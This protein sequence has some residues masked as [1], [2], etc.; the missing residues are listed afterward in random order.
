[1]AGFLGTRVGR[2][3]AAVIGATLLIAAALVIGREIPGRP[4]IALAAVAVVLALG[5]TAADAALIPLLLLPVVFVIHRVSAGAL[6]LSISDAALGLATLVALVFTK[7]PFSAPLRNLLWLTVLY[8]FATL[9]TVVANPFLAN[10]VEWVH[11]WTLVGGALV[12]GWTIGRGGHARAGLT[13]VMVT[14]LVLAMITIAQGLRQYAG[15]DFQPV[16]VSW[17]YGMHKNFIGTVVAFAAVV[18]YARPV[19]LGWPRR[20]SLSVFWILAVAI[21]FTQSRQAIMGLGVALLLIALRGDRHRR[22]SKVIVVAV[23]PALFFVGTLVKDQLASGNAFNS[24]NQRLT[25]FQDTLT[26]WERS[27][28][29]GYGLRFWNQPGAPLHFQPP[30]A[31][32]EVLASAGIIGLLGFLALV[33]GVLIVLWRIDPAYGTLAVAVVL[34]RFVQGQFDLFWVAGQVSVPFVVAGICLGVLELR[35][36]G[37]EPSQRL[38]RAGLPAAVPPG[39]IPAE[40]PR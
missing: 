21:A 13:L 2:W 1:M 23:I 35:N 39:P 28:W 40:T 14:A 37:Q 11:A 29:V 18:A 27:P 17:P 19:W 22:R 3:L 8:Q 30:N 33:L 31:E 20:W 38:V 9:F 12:V 32:L 6:D 7:R 4:V 25:W 34:S 16:Y 36:E 24:A 15:G 26:A 5:V 10:A